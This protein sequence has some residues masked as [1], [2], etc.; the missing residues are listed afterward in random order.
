MSV[1]MDPL[2]LAAA[3]GRALRERRLMAKL[4]QEALAFESGLGRNYVS[5]LELGQNQPTIGT[6][7]RLAAVLKV[8]PESL[9]I[10][11]GQRLAQMGE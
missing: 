6:L 9:I 3:F 10:E 5:L 4:T 11:T 8:S 1:D 7:F 2:L